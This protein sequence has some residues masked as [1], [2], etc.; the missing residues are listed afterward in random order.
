[1]KPIIF[2]GLVWVFVCAHVVAQ[3]PLQDG[4]YDPS[5]L[6]FNLI[7]RN[8]EQAPIVITKV[9]VKSE[10]TA[11]V[12]RCMSGSEPLM[13][14]AEYI[15]HYHVGTPL[16]VID[17]DPMLKIAPNDVVSVKISLVPS[18]TGACG[19]W[20]ANTTALVQL[21]SGK[22][23]YSNPI[24]LTSADLAN[25]Q[26][27]SPSDEELLA[28]L[29]M[30]NPEARVNALEKLPKSSI[31]RQDVVK[32]LTVKLD[33]PDS[34]V[35][36]TA[37][38]IAAAMKITEVT[39]KIRQVMEAAGADDAFAYATVLVKMRDPHAVGPLV[40]ALGDGKRDLYFQ[41]KDELITIQDPTVPS[42]V[43]TLLLANQAWATA[44]S[45]E[46]QS[47]QY[48]T[49]A[50]VLV[51]Y[52]DMGSV[53]I[54]SRLI[55]NDTHDGLLS[56]NLLFGLLQHT[57]SGQLVQDPFLIGFEPAVQKAIASSE[58]N[59][60]SNALELACRLPL[61]PE[62]HRHLVEAGLMEQES[63]VKSSAAECAGELHYTDLAQRIAALAASEKDYQLHNRFCEA[64]TS[65]ERP[66]RK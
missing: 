59:T 61:R 29:K 51:E 19:Y 34:G 3:A 9:G 5:L 49:I 30:N 16:T 31:G 60:R 37:A 13:P 17:A 28:A 47:M 1:M 11:G 58:W 43:R 12:F 65:L 56:R 27:R 23:L 22:T 32:I 44:S 4:Q 66:C 41:A 42:K 46:K 36:M 8:P 38:N 25:S 62:E 54:L 35:R 33:D 10:V 2:A 18:A 20:A 48:L 15:I 64:L 24:L 39:F 53:E 21:D 57:K 40:L 63:W 14:L 7:I 52:E 55:E 45:T 6:T 50:E 26:A